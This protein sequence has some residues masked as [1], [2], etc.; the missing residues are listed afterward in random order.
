MANVSRPLMAL[1]A[2]TVA[3]FALWIVA[4][5][6]HTAGTSGT[7][8]QPGVGSYSKDIN[9]AK[10]VAKV[11]AGNTAR[12][13]AAEAGRPTSTSS[14][15]SAGAASG[16][17]KH[18][19]TAQRPHTSQAHKAVGPAQTRSAVHKSSAVRKSSAGHRAAH[20]VANPG[21][22]ATAA[23]RL[24]AVERAL[25]QRKVLALLFYNPAAPDD[26]AVKNELASIPTRR[27]E[28]VKLAIPLSELP[29]YAGLTAQVPVNFSP[30]LVVV[31]RK[32]QAVEQAGFADTFAIAQLIDDAQ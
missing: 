32:Y 14:V 2:V 3:F 31:N 15:T 28:V 19:A 7:T 29:S 25:A 9:A 18:A 24:A 1:L 11:V 30:T 27:G 22:A 12:Q 10:N 20:A 6:P 17:G 21:V 13:G 26:Q 8:Q 16:P 23:G 5:K 4:L